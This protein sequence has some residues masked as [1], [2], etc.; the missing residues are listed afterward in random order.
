MIICV[1][2]THPKKVKTLLKELGYKFMM[3]NPEKQIKENV[4]YGFFNPTELLKVKTYKTPFFFNIVSSFAHIEIGHPIYRYDFRELPDGLVLF[5]EPNTEQIIEALEIPF[6]FKQTKDIQFS[7][8]KIKA[9]YGTSKL[10][11]L[12]N[13]FIMTLPSRTA[14][15]FMVCFLQ[16]VRKNDIKCFTQFITDNRL[17]GSGNN[18]SYRALEEFIQTLWP[19]FRLAT[20]KTEK[21]TKKLISFRKKNPELSDSISRFMF[22]NRTYK[23][24][25]LSDYMDDENNVIYGISN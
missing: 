16:S 19:V 5:K 10:A 6:K 13:N 14:E 21:A 3:Y 2:N 1:A 25:E 18:A 11:L 17:V 24:T 7:P 20:K 4:H 8:T 23:G 12:W 15:A 9:A 22:W